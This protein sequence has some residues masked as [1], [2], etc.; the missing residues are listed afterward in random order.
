[1][2]AIKAFLRWNSSPKSVGMALSGVHHQQCTRPARRN[3]A[4]SAERRKWKER[5]KLSHKE[6]KL[7]LLEETE[8]AKKPK[9]DDGNPFLFLVVFPVVMT[10]LVVFLRQDL[11]EELL[12]KAPIR[13]I[14][15]N[16]QAGES[17]QDHQSQT[18]VASKKE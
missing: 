10:G 9:D 8:N 14:P 1:M 17:K 16:H 5:P 7:L 6:Q 13:L 12:G 2:F 15:R 4:T 18:M 3:L 11:R